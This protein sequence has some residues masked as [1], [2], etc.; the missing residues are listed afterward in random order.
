MQFPFDIPTQHVPTQPTQ[1]TQLTHPLRLQFKKTLGS[2]PARLLPQIMIFHRRET[3][4]P[5]Q[6]AKPIWD[7]MHLPLLPSKIMRTKPSP[8]HDFLV[9]LLPNSSI[10]ITALRYAM[11][12]PCLR[13]CAKA[14]VIFKGFAQSPTSI[15]FENNRI[16]L[17]IIGS[18]SMQLVAAIEPSYIF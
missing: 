5:P 14:D 10:F 4:R 17:D 18:F 12:H 9:P 13:K 2:S 1:P 7:K 16:E 6:R 8:K 11:L 15:N 3:G